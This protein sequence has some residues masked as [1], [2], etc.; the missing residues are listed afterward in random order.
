MCGCRE[1]RAREGASLCALVGV[2]PGSQRHVG[3]GHEMGEP[4]PAPGREP[5]GTQRALVQVARAAVFLPALAVGAG[6]VS[7]QSY[8]FVSGEGGAEV[9]PEQMRGVGGSCR[10]ERRRC[11]Y[12]AGFQPRADRTMGYAQGQSVLHKTPRVPPPNVLGSLQDCLCPL[13]PPS[14]G[15]PSACPSSGL[16]TFSD[17]L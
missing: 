14:S 11:V 2:L 12:L 8:V 10:A 17:F 13:A 16:Y 6:G 1:K 5:L 9:S 4:G 15:G 3:I 7:C